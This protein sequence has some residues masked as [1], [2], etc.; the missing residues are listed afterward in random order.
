MGGFFFLLCIAYR[1]ITWQTPRC[2][3]DT[4]E[5]VTSD[6]LP[7][8]TAELSPFKGICLKTGGTHLPATILT[9]GG[10]ETA[11]C[12]DYQCRTGSS[13]GSYWLTVERGG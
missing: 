4:T 10:A 12:G 3:T 2:Y 13:D 9:K 6:L 8:P 7:G 5:P 11:K 1:Q